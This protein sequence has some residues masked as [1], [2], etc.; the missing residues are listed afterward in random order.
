MPAILQRLTIALLLVVMS[1][2][3]GESR[4][5]D[6]LQEKLCA[7]DNSVWPTGG[8]RKQQLRNTELV[9]RFGDA[10][11]AIYPLTDIELLNVDNIEHLFLC[12]S[13]LAAE[14]LQQNSD[15]K[16]PRRE[17]VLRIFGSGGENQAVELYRKPIMP[18]FRFSGMSFVA[19]IATDAAYK[20]VF[21]ITNIDELR[22]QQLRVKSVSAAA[23][24]AYVMGVLGEG[25]A[26]HAL[27]A[28]QITKSDSGWQFIGADIFENCQPRKWRDI[29][30]SRDGKV[31]IL[32]ENIQQDS[33]GSS[34]VLCID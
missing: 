7:E 21:T 26:P 16:H 30:V 17:D 34:A 23:A 1:A 4:E 25:Y 11:L 31:E 14:E 33:T 28:A 18:V 20:P 15:I 3:G 10:C 27:C 24:L 5:I 6:E 22:K 8:D 9:R 13:F 32:A 12:R 29:F 2:C 19:I